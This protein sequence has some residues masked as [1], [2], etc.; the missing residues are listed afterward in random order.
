MNNRRQANRWQINQ[1][2]KLKLEGAQRF[3]PCVVKD[4]NFSGAQISLRMKL[5]EDAVLKFTLVLSEKFTLDIKAWAAWHRSR[6]GLNLYGLYFTQVK[7]ED[8]EKIYRFI[9]NYFPGEAGKLRRQAVVIE[10]EGEARQDRRIFARLPL[11]LPL[12]WIGQDAAEE[13][14]AETCDF[15]A[16]GVGLVTDRQLSQ[17]APLEMWLNIPDRHKPL[18]TRGEVVWS[19]MLEPNKCRAGIELERADLMAMS[20][21]FRV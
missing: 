18:Y 20:R 19:Q 4:I 21:L 14:T 3:A 11:H 6:N 5:P 15:S 12:R 9:Y 8:K 1:Q 10:K 16:K 17:G 7:E 2:A 13:C